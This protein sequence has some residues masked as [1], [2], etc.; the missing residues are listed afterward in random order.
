MPA[1]YCE[2]FTMSWVEPRSRKWSNY[3]QISLGWFSS[4]LPLHRWWWWWWW[5]WWSPILTGW[6]R[7]VIHPRI[8]H[9]NHLL[10][11]K[12]AIF[13]WFNP[14]KLFWVYIMLV[15]Y[16]K[17]FLKPCI[18]LVLL[19]VILTTPIKQLMGFHAATAQLRTSFPIHGLWHS[20]I[21]RGYFNSRTSHQPINQS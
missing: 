6:I 9:P 10:L 3:A 2:N 7:V 4:G 13:L 15:I 8:K 21:Y 12:H 11:I 19:N 14:L 20:P 1:V 5:W 17:W 18:K 16:S